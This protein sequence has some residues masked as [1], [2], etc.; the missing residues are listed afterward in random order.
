MTATRVLGRGKQRGLHYE[1]KVEPPEA[2][3]ES[4]GRMKYIPKKMLW[5]VVRD[6]RVEEVVET[7]IKA[8]QTGK[9][10]DGKIFVCSVENAIRVRTGEGGEAAIR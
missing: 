4:R 5:M 8:N 1:L 2:L 6:A 3:K 10:G 9:I 7:I